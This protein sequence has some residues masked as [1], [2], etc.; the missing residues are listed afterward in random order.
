MLLYTD[1][2]PTSTP[3]DALVVKAI[4]N[5][6]PPILPK[7]GKLPHNNSV[8]EL[9]APPAAPPTKPG[10]LIGIFFFRGMESF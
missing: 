2:K 6:A 8:P 1:C 3:N 9:T 5:S 4:S 7:S 10:W